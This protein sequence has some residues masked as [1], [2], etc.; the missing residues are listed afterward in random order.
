MYSTSGDRYA[1][2]YS[3]LVKLIGEGPSQWNIMFVHKFK[4][5]GIG[6]NQ[7]FFLH[8]LLQHLRWKPKVIISLISNPAIKSFEV[9]TICVFLVKGSND[10]HFLV[11]CTVASGLWALISTMLG[12]QW[13]MP[14]RVIDDLF[15]WQSCC[16]KHRRNAVVKK[17]II[18]TQLK[19]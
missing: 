15:C 5:V 6:I 14:K 4:G 11:H 18:T 19:F 1:S 9:L 16:G 10:M 8:Y 2:V 17:C 7:L 13:V 3:S 12:V